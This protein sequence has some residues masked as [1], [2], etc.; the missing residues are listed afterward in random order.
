MRCLGKD[1][2]LHR[3]KVTT[4]MWPGSYTVRPQPVV[5]QEANAWQM[6]LETERTHSVTPHQDPSTVIPQ[7]QAA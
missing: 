4:S 5:D 7:A 3:L 6:S 2:A 1:M